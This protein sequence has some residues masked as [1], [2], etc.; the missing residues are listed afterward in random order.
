MKKKELLF[1]IICVSSSVIALL[2]SISIGTTKINIINIIKNIFNN[3]TVDEIDLYIIKSIRI[4]RALCAMLCG[5]I[6]SVSG[7]CFQTVFKNPLADSY[8][9]GIS[10]GAS[11]SVSLGLLL[12]LSIN[13]VYSLPVIAFTG[14]LATSFLLFFN[15]K[16]NINSMLLFG[17]AINF[18]LSACTS[19]FIFLGKKQVQFVIYWTM[20]SLSSSSYLKAAIFTILSV[21]ILLFLLRRNK[22]MDLLLLNETTA[23]SLGINANKERL[24][25]LIVSSLTTSVIVAYCGVIGFIGLMCPHITR[26]FLGPKHKPLIICSFPLG[27]LILQISDIISRIVI[28]NSELPIGIITSIIGAPIFFSLLLK[29]KSTIYD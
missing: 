3:F 19:L 8:V 25:L 11:F 4:P 29:R 28:P 17:I 21:F 10:S 20:G 15:G 27:A 1:F 23:F 16:K 22:K 18:F 2:I 5:G 7:L 9:L 13:S 12:G 26:K 24:L 6:L 14:S